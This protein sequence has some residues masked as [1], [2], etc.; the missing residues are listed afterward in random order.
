M[1]FVDPIVSPSRRVL[2]QRINTLAL[3]VCVVQWL[4]LYTGMVLKLNLKRAYLTVHILMSII[5]LL[6]EQHFHIN[7]TV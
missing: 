4:T 7:S 3:S 1:S 5:T 2:Y 6:L